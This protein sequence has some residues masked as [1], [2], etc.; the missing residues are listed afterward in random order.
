MS[1]FP[2]HMDTHAFAN[3]KKGQIPF[4]IL[5]HTLLPSTHLH[6]HDYVELSFVTKGHGVETINGKSHEMVPGTVSILLP[7]QLHS[8]ASDPHSPLRLYCC[9]FD[10]S[11]LTDS[12]FDIQLCKNL[13]S[14]GNA[15]PSHILLG[16]SDQ[17]D[18]H[19]L[20]SGMMREYKTMNV[21]RNS[22]IRSKLVEALLLF[23]RSFPPSSVD[24]QSPSLED[25]RRLD[26]E[27][28]RYSNT[29]YLQRLSLRELSGRFG[30]SPSYISRLFKQHLGAHFLEHLHNLR[31]K[32]ACSLLATTEMSVYDISE[33]AGFE[34]FRT[35]SRIFK[36]MN[37]LTPSEYRKSG[38]RD[39][40]QH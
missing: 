2:E 29:H 17:V 8:I 26:W 31:I 7:H 21:G 28:I 34:S 11:L 19:R 25:S 5:E 1:T 3:P 15:M 37:G 12:P 38:S 9:M 24:R 30:V 32:R 16:N 4:Y 18:M 22:S 40:G 13:M 10:I 23:V 33:E 14:A 27:I 35:F 39:S 6:H 20:C 36:Q